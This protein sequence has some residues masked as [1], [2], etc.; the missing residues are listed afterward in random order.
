MGRYETEW[1]R[2]IGDNP[3]PYIA[4]KQV[5]RARK[6]HRYIVNRGDPDYNHNLRKEICS[7]LRSII[8]GK[9]MDH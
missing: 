2:T 9:C 5:K 4:V 7:N 1:K 6:T 3:C 8:I